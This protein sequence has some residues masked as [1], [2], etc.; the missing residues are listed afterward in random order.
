MNRDYERFPAD[1]NGDVLWQMFEDGD[2]LKEAHD[3]EFSL[4]FEDE[5]QAQRCAIYLLQEEQK[6]SMI[7]ETGEDGL[8]WI[9]T[10]YLYMQPNHADIVDLEH[11]FNKIAQDFEGEYDGWGCMAYVFDDETPES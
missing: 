3:I 4:R 6:I 9:L 5:S 10:I 2:E 7:E 8:R 11:W 1:E